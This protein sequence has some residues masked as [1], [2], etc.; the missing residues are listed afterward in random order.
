M[1]QIWF[2]VLHRGKKEGQSGKSVAGRL[3]NRQTN[4]QSSL[5][6]VGDLKASEKVLNQD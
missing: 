1:I 5:T 2:S 6:K 4:V 3:K